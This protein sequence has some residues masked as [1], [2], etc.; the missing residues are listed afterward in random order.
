LIFV[1]LAVPVL[2][3]AYFLGSHGLPYLYD[4]NWGQAV[5]YLGL[6]IPLGWLVWL[7]LYGPMKRS[8]T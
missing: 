1:I 2:W 4:G 8:W 5:G 3:S 6:F 7:Y